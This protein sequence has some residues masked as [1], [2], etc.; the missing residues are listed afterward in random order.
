MGWFKKLE[1]T[2]AAFEKM[3]V[4]TNAAAA[5]MAG[6]DADAWLAGKSL[7]G[8]AGR[9]VYGQ[10]LPRAERDAQLRPVV[11]APDPEEQ[12]RAEAAARSEQRAGYL[13]PQRPSIRFTRIPTRERSQIRD[14]AAALGASGLAA[15]PDLVFGLYRVPDHIGGITVDRLVEWE[16]VHA[17]TGQLPSTP[18]PQ[19]VWFDADEQWV[20]RR[21]GEPMV[22]DEDLALAYLDRAGIGPE[23]TIGVSRMLVT[24]HQEAGGENSS[25]TASYV[26]GVYVWHAAGVGGPATEQLREQ[27]PITI[28]AAADTRVEVLNW[29]GIRQAVAPSSGHPPLSPSP[30]PYLPSTAQ[31]LLQSYLEIVGVQPAD[32]YAAAVTEDAPKDL[33][34][35]ST[36][37]GINVKSN[38]GET[39]LAADGRNYPR[40]RGG[41]RIVIAY[42]DRPDYVLGRDRFAAYERDVLQSQ[43]ACGAERRPIEVEDLQDRLPRGLRGVVKATTAVARLVTADTYN[44]LESRPPYR[45]CWPPTK[46]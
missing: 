3:L 39:S 14:V 4:D 17:D 16:V 43:L 46:R 18:P 10:H 41:A 27:R 26:T 32:C 20:A 25:L 6:V 12:G 15:R 29:A 11:L 30:F 40:L 44:T 31:E 1:Q 19:A 7:R 35:V 38:V 13:A 37:H 8:P 28:D 36:V 9:Y 2:S 24:Q 5:G 22:Y 42:R 33:D 21:T 34:Q 45:Y 23:A